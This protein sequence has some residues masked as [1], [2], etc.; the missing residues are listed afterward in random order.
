MN[1]DDEW[2]DQLRRIHD[3]DKARRQA[4]ETSQ[5]ATEPVITVELLL[6]QCRAHE[7]LRQVQNML[8]NGG[9]RLQFYENV[10]GY[11]QAVVLM[12]NGSISNATK[13]PSI[14]DVDAAIIV[15]ANA[16][17]VF[18]NDAALPEASPDVLKEALLDLA[19]GFVGEDEL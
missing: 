16:E 14:E 17:G 15:G 2:Q 10:G 5:A 18:L 9:G 7:L 11:E 19:R 12:W 6:R 3:S 8:L 13:P 4:E 1:S